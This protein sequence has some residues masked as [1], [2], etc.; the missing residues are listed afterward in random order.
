MAFVCK[1]MLKAPYLDGLSPFKAR[2]IQKEID[3]YNSKYLPVDSSIN[4]FEEEIKLFVLKIKMICRRESVVGN[5]TTYL[6]KEDFTLA[7]YELERLTLLP[8]NMKESVFHM[9]CFLLQKEGFSCYVVS[10]T[11]D[12]SISWEK[13]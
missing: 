3:E 9:L 10:N 5:N 2:C 6:A 12:L 4:C 8:V 1:E 13:K 7:G 11:K